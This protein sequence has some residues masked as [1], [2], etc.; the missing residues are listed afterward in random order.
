LPSYH[1]PRHDLFAPLPNVPNRPCFFFDRLFFVGGRLALL[2]LSWIAYIPGLLFL[3]PF[4]EAHGFFMPFLKSYH[5][6][7]GPGDPVLVVFDDVPLEVKVSIFSR[8]ALLL[9]DGVD[10]F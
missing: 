5:Y 6:L 8:F 1:I 7:G 4:M 10:V 9:A 3:P 2:L